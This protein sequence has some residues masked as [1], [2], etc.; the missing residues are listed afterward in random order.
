MHVCISLDGAMHL[1]AAANLLVLYIPTNQL[2]SSPVTPAAGRKDDVDSV[3]QNAAALG[4]TS[5]RTWAHSIFEQFP[6]QTAPGQYDENG[7]KALD[8]V[9]DSARR[10][11]IK[12]VLSFID[13]WKYYN[14]VDQYVDW[15]GPARTMPLP[16]DEGGDTD[17]QVS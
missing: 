4:M 17:T 10:H 1:Q 3:F 14:G 11:G 16:K 5:A 7:V 8:Y 15:C 12:L 13:N 2:L 9:I 6:F